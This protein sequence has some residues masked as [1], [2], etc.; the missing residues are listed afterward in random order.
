MY[1]YIYIYL[2]I[3]LYIQ[4]SK[5]LYPNHDEL[6][7]DEEDYVLDEDKVFFSADEPWCLL[8]IA[9]Q[10]RCFTRQF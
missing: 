8:G 9:R 6:C 2:S 1:I 3:Y 10:L 4:A 5:R 7:Q